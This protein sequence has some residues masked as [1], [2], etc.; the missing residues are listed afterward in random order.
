MA[1]RAEISIPQLLIPSVP[2]CGQ[3]AAPSSNDALARLSIFRR[4]TRKAAQAAAVLATQME[5]S[6]L[7]A[8]G[9]AQYVAVQQEADQLWQRLIGAGTL[10]ALIVLRIERTRPPCWLAVKRPA[11]P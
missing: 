4:S 6:E 10:W 7:E 2:L 9:Q 1:E 11:R 5:C 8:A 3:L